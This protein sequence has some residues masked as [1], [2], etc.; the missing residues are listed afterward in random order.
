MRLENLN[1]GS[2]GFV[3]QAPPRGDSTYFSVYRLVGALEQW[4]NRAKQ[5]AELARLDQALRQDIGVTDAD[6]W[7]ETRKRPWQP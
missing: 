1:I 4:R 3:N 6:I 7:Q 2:A 5:R